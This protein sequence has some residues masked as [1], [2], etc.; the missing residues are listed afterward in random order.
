MKVGEGELEERGEEVFERRDG[1]GGGAEVGAEERGE[2]E[3][4]EEEEREGEDPLM[5]PR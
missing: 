1:P 2:G 4:E 3:G 5:E